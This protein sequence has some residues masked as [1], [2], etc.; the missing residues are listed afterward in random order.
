[1]PG[2]AVEIENKAGI[3]RITCGWKKPGL[4]LDAVRRYW[5]DVHSP[6]I[7]RRPGIWEYR[8]YQFD[9][10]QP[11]FAPLDGID[12][13]C[14]ADEQLMWLSDVRYADD[15]A[16]AIFAAEPADNV[17]G[18]LLGDIDLI[19]DQST[20]YKAVDDM[21][22]TLVDDS[23][24][25]PPQGQPPVP[26]FGLFLRSRSA[27]PDFRAFVVALAGRWA[28]TPGVRRVRYSLLEAPDVAAE[29]AA[30]YPIKTH[31]PERQY[32]AWIDLAIDDPAV[33]ATL[34]TDGMTDH[35]RAVHAYPVAANYTSNY[36]GR[37]TFVGLRGYPAWDALTTIGGYNQAQPAIMKWMF[38]PVA[39]GVTL[40]PVSR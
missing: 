35:I 38:G 21:A 15:A 11:L 6:A 32:Q 12:Q 28:A 14:S 5:R 7:A 27:E 39:D 34:A 20:T 30:G 8:H 1:M 9:A 18:E 23:A 17:R 37:P 40:E 3:C 13:S 2:T 10:V 31:P 36:D 16:L 4:P 22:R 33:A 26:A 29:R 24:M 19:V 25:V